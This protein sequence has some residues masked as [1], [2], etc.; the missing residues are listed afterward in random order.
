[1]MVASYRDAYLAAKGVAVA[2]TRAGNVIGGGDWSADRL[3]PDAVRAWMAGCAAIC[4]S[5]SGC[6]GITVTDDTTP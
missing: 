4:A 1:M 3:I 5:A 2:T 6:A